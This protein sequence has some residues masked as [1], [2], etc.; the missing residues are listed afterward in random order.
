MENNELATNIINS[1][2]C[3][4][5]PFDL[6]SCCPNHMLWEAIKQADAFTIAQQDIP[7]FL[8]SHN[9]FFL[10]PEPLPAIY[11]GLTPEY[12]KINCADLFA[13]HKTGIGEL[14]IQEPMYIV[15]SEFRWMIVLT[16]EN[17]Q[18]ATQLCVIVYAKS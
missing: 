3:G 17:T 18:S 5:T 11:N 9:D 4:A 6:W 10:L 13:K 8:I 14:I 12:A 7:T 15:D 2:F 1:F 16:T